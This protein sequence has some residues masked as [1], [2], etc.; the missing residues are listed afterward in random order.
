MRTIKEPKAPTLKNRVL[1]F[2]GTG[3]TAFVAWHIV[4]MLKEKGLDVSV[5]RIE[6]SDPAE[7][8][9]LQCLYFGFPIY[10]CDMPHLVRE[11]VHALPEGNGTPVRLF[12]TMAYF[13]GKALERAAALFSQKG[14]VTTSSYERRMPGTDGLAFVKKDGRAAGKLLMTK[15]TRGI[16]RRTDGIYIYQV[17][18]VTLVTA[19]AKYQ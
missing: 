10:A 7:C 14:Y 17:T 6:G 11:Y 18:P 5:G 12:C 19:V 2:S 4:T 16:I 3:N 13:S 15:Q 1:Y 9:D 8:R